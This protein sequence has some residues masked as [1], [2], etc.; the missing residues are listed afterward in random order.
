VAVLPEIVEIKNNGRFGQRNEN[1]KREIFEIEK[2]FYDGKIE[3]AIRENWK[4]PV[5]PEINSIAIA[6]PASSME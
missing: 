1:L 6:P 4:R 3:M 2:T 5:G